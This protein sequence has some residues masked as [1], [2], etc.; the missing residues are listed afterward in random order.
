MKIDKI[1]LSNNIISMYGNHSAGERHKQSELIHQGESVKN[2]IVQNRPAERVSLSGSECLSQK[3]D[4]IAFTGDP[5]LLTKIAKQ[6][7]DAGENLDVPAW[8]SKMGGADWFDKVLKNVDKNETFYEAVVALVVAG[9]L[10]PVCVLAMPGAEMEDKQMSATKN[11][12]SAFI[13][14]VLSNLILNPCSTAVNKITDSLNGKNPTKYI[15]NMDYVEALKNEDLLPGLKTT[16]G[17]SF[18]TT[19][20][21][22][23]DVGVSPM[24]AAMTLALT[25]IIVNTLFGKSKKKKEEAKKQPIQNSMNQM[26]VL[27]AIRMQNSHQ[28]QAPSFNGQQQVSFSGNKQ[29]QNAPSFTGN[30]SKVIELAKDVA[31]KKKSALGKLKD[32][33][34]NFLGEPIAKLIG[35]IADTKAGKKLV[36]GSAHFEKPSARWSDMASIA[37]TYFYVQN[38]AKSKKIDEERKLPLMINN[39]MVTVASS[40]AAFLIDKFTDKPMEDIFKGYLKKHEST[41]HDKSN[42]NAVKTLAKALEGRADADEVKT[43]MRHSDDLLEGGLDGMSQN[44]KD[45]IEALKNNDVVKRA[46]KEKIIENDDVAKI[47]AAGFEKQASKI[48]KNIS[49]TKSLTVFTLT[50][51]FL[52][53]V[54]M[55]PVIGKVVAMVNKKLGRGKYKNENQQL[56]TNSIPPAGSETFGMK[57]FMNGLNQTNNQPRNSQ[58][59]FNFNNQVVEKDDDDHDE[60][61]DD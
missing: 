20:K 45:A 40:T 28:T 41:L 56:N 14:F 7:L 48:Y 4:Q 11:A 21:K 9:V 51:R 49:K 8:A 44:L 26:A 10:K 50:V 15:K 47:A 39:V 42:I 58:N 5:K 46:I 43:L 32:S 60:D 1:T 55:T 24:K 22:V 23:W 29:N 37:I 52:V 19:Y 3:N 53:T 35:K 31:P 25:P 36:E 12:A 57:D 59:S 2:N 13:G 18:K 33:Y 27:N 30:V 61:D 54:L 34:C 6:A 17:D 38:T 16:L